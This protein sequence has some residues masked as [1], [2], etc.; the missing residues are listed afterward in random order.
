M[1]VRKRNEFLEDA[2]SEGEGGDGGY[3][4]DAV[5]ESRGAVL[6]RASKRLKSAMGGEEFESDDESFHSFEN[7]GSK[8]VVARKAAEED[9]SPPAAGSERFQLGDDFEDDEEDQTALQQ[10]DATLPTPSIKTLK[11]VA[12]AEKAARKSGV[13]YISRVPP[14]MKPQTLRHFLA[15]HAPKGL[16]RIFL[17]PEDHTAH[18]ARKRR[19]GN[20][21]KSFTDGWVEFTSKSDAQ[22][23]VETLNG[24][25]IGGKKGGF[26]CEDLWNLR[27]LRGFKWRHLTE[28]VANEDAERGAR[29]REEIRRTRVGNRGFV[30]DV[31]RGKMLEGMERRAVERG[32][33]G[34][35]K[36]DGGE[37]VG[38]KKREREFKQR[39]VRGGEER[40]GEVQRSG[41]LKNVL[42]K[43]F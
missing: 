28:Q 22:F 43:I 8:E 12:A 41:E 1:V 30:A 7:E 36:G 2:E 10:D 16:G 32:R 42:S 18:L 19:G 24:Q 38:V 13:V 23:A 17:T 15:P 14:F 5:G 25:L 39:K 26:Y 3:D 29:L 20:K 35:E 31:E 11:S 9:A 21:K 4:S 27:Y 33:D 37:A 40:K 6:G 34:H